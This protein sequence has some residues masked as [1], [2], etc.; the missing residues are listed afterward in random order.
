MI[1]VEIGHLMIEEMITSHDRFK[2]FFTSTARSIMLIAISVG[3]ESLLRSFVPVCIVTTSAFGFFFIGGFVQCFISLVFAPGKQ[4][5]D[6][7]LVNFNFLLIFH[8]LIPFTMESPIVRA[9]FLKTP[10]T[11][12]KTPFLN[13]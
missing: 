3:V 7:L 13:S 9:L 4:L 6:I 11:S 8:L 5:T 2:F 12:L 1:S 10:K